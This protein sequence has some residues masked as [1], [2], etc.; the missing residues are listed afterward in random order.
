MGKHLQLDSQKSIQDV[1]THDREL[2][3]N[4]DKINAYEETFEEPRKSARR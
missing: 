3:A 2:K 4:I 1:S